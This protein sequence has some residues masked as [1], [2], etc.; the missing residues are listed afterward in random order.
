VTAERVIAGLAS[1]FGLLALLLACVGL[2]GLLSYEVARRT[3]EIGIRMSLGAERRDVTR[4][5][6]MRGMRL[7]AV[8]VGGGAV[9]GLALTR[10][11]SSLL[12]GVKPA[13][14]PTYLFIALL[15]TGVALLASYIP[16]WQAAK[17]DPMV[18]LRYE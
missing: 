13:D 4:L 14:W 3:R 9:G 15:L 17:V 1:F 11:L 16:A 2:Y 8:G 6:V 10:V 5:I 12:Y 7:T 18:A